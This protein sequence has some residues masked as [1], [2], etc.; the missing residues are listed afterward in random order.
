MMNPKYPDYVIPPENEDQ[1]PPQWRGVLFIVAI[2]QAMLALLFA[3]SWLLGA[4]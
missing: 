4:V 2:M 3:A 1:R